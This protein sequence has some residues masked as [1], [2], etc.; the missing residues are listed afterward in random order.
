ML[1]HLKGSGA[2]VKRKAVNQVHSLRQVKHQ[3]LVKSD[4]CGHLLV[5]LGEEGIEV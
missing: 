2:L 5:S 1:Q 3:N 4:L